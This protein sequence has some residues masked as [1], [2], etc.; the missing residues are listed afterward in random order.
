MA[1][2]HQMVA[3]DVARI[4]HLVRECAFP[5]I[6]EV[7]NKRTIM[8]CPD[9]HCAKVLAL[10][11]KQDGYQYEIRRGLKTNAVYVQAWY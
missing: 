1:A 2:S 5:E 11:I 3:P 7:T 10:R 6:I 8:W 4:E 9:H